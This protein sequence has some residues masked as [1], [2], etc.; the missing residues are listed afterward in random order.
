MSSFT[1]ELIVKPLKDGK[2]W[3]LMEEFEYYS[4][5]PDSG[6]RVIIPAGFTTDFASTPRIT[7]WLL[8]PWGSYGKATVVHDYLREGNE[9]I[10]N[11][12]L[13]PVSAKT[14]DWIFMEAMTV[15]K[16]KVPVRI[17]MYSAVVIS[18]YYNNAINRIKRLFKK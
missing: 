15:L 18:R 12:K 7:W 10:V 2:T 13:M 8:P 17:V 14:A 3:E 5:S 9:M 6:T 1:K 16:V 11:N 4:R